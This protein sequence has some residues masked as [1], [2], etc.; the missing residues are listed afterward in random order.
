MIANGSSVYFE[1]LQAIVGYITDGDDMIF[2]KRVVAMA[3]M[4]L[5]QCYCATMA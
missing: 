5:Q 3:Q 4:Q 1:Q 2:F